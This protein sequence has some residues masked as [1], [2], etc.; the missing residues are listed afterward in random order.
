MFSHLSNSRIKNV[1]PAVYPLP[2]G[3]HKRWRESTRSSSP[4]FLITNVRNDT[5]HPWSP[6]KGNQE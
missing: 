2:A 4:G 1:I 3:G 6:D 5:L